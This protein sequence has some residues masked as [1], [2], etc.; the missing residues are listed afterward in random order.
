[1]HRSLLLKAVVISLMISVALYA[2]GAV[3][4]SSQDAAPLA[5]I[6]LAEGVYAEVL[7]SSPSDR[8]PDQTLYL[9]RFTFM[10]DGEIF[11]HGHPG[12]TLL[13]VVSGTFGWTLVEGTAQVVRGAATGATDPVEEV[14]EPGEEVILNPGDAIFYEDDVIHTA[15]GAGDEPAIVHGTLLLT[16]GEPLLMPAEMEMATPAS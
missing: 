15:R 8:A 4:A 14:M 11:P 16:T 5:G 7:A 1:M 10:P 12:T 13:S 2:A 3:V 9:A 6:E